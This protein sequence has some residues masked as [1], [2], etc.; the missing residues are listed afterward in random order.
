MVIKEYLKQKLIEGWCEAKQHTAGTRPD[1]QTW[2]WTRCQTKRVHKYLIM[3]KRVV[4]TPTWLMN[5]SLLVWKWMELLLLFVSVASLLVCL[6]FASDVRWHQ[7]RVSCVHTCL[8]FLFPPRSNPHRPLHSCYLWNFLFLFALSTFSFWHALTSGLRS[9]RF[10][11]MLLP[12]ICLP[13][14][15][16]FPTFLLPSNEH[17]ILASFSGFFRCFSFFLLRPRHY[18]LTCSSII[19]ASA[20]LFARPTHNIHSHILLFECGL[21][22]LKTPYFPYGAVGWSTFTSTL[23]FCEPPCLAYSPS[24]SRATIPLYEPSTSFTT[25]PHSHP[26]LRSQHRP[27][28]AHHKHDNRQERLKDSVFQYIKWH[29]IR[30]FEAEPSA[31]TVLYGWMVD[32]G[33]SY[34]GVCELSSAGAF[35]CAY[36]LRRCS[37]EPIGS[38]SVPAVY[39][40]F[41]LSSRHYFTIGLTYLSFLQEVHLQ[42]SVPMPVNVT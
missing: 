24:L 36:S 40:F 1:P 16:L 38:L 17:T 3:L 30:R 21:P 12:N 37:S 5:T 18:F 22:Y 8:I 34:A 31:F 14:S 15:L 33:L 9:H 26:V 28:D 39:S 23:F 29:N 35:I 19:D 6:F 32:I 13:I 10:F 4:W 25:L 7:F 11:L 20:M 41:P 42:L 27:D 2:T